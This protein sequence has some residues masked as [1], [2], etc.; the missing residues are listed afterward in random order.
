MT[1]SD[2]DLL[3]LSGILGVG[4]YLSSYGLLQAGVLRG[5]SYTY[6]TLNMLAAGFVLLSLTSDFNLASALIQ[7]SWILISLVGIARLILI[8]RPIRFDAEDQMLVDELMPG[9]P[10]RLARRVIQNGLWTDAEAGTRLTEEDQPVTHLFF[11]KEGE[12]RVLSFGRPISTIHGGLVGEVNVM[13]SGPASAT[14]E[15]TEPSRL[16]AISGDRL[17]R[18]SSTSSEIGTAMVDRL[19]QS[20]REKLVRANRGL[21]EMEADRGQ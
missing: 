4:I 10:S 2:V 17:R 19:A 14:V 3:T 18:L 12:A 6:A 20:T 11:I 9:L 8:R 1:I 21:A 15:L 5:A 7:I 16:F 13:E